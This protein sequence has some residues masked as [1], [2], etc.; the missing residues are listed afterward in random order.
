MGHQDN[1]GGGIKMKD[2]SK[3][4]VL[5]RVDQAFGKMSELLP[6]WN[7]IPEDFK[8]FMGTGEAKK[9]VQA[10][11]NIFYSGVR[12]TEV[13]MKNGIDRTVVMRHLMSV[14]HSWEP[15]HEHKT[16]GVAYLMS[17]WFE[18]FKYEVEKEKA[19]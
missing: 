11:A 17:L 15:K 4:T 14:L 5:D 6:A 1:S 2:W 9:W 12:V 18:D 13:K 7:D 16:A 10:V 8:S 19:V 3:P